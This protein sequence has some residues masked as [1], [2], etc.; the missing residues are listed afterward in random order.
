M[1]KVSDKIEFCTCAASPIYKLRNY[2]ILHRFI[3]GKDII[4]IG[5]VLMP[6]IIEKDI[7]NSNRK[8]LQKRI[9]ES[10]AFDI[11]LNP[12]RGDLL[13]ITFG[14]KSVWQKLTYGYKYTGTSWVCESYDPLKWKWH[15]EVDLAGKIRNAKVRKKGLT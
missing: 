6:F 10:D 13:E 9:N 14:T 15:H 4:V 5:E 12:K 11:N 3:K 8:F 1:C 2:W 7:D